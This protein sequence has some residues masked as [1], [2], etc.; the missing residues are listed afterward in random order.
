MVE[1]SAYGEGIQITKEVPN[2]FREILS[3]DAVAFVAKLAREFTPRVEERLQARQDRQERINAGEMPDFLP[4]TKDVRE[5]DWKIAPIP[6]ALQDRRVEITGPPDRKMLINALNCRAPTYMTDFEDANCPT[7]HNMLDSQRNLK[8]AIERTISFDDPKTGKHYTLNDEVAVLIARPR[9]WHLFEKHMLVDGKQVP[10]GI[11]DFGLYFFHNAQ[12][13]LDLGHGPYFYLP[14]MESHLEARLWN[15]IFS[16]IKKFREHDMLLPDRNT[17]TMTV[18]FMRAYS[19]LTIKTCHQRGAHAMGGMA[20]QIPRSDDPEWTEFAN[21]KVREDKER[22][23]KD[24]HDGTWVAHPGM[25]GLAMEAFNEYMPQPNQIDKIPDVNPSAADL[26]EKPEGQITMDGF[27]NN[28]SVGVQ[29]LGAWLAGRGAVPVFNLMEDA[30][31]AEI[32]RAQVW[33]WIHHP[34][35]IL[36]DGT[37]VTVDLFRQVLDE[38]LDKIKNDIVGPE[39]WEQDEFGTAA[40][41]FDRISTQDEFVEFLTLPGYEYLD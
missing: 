22:E 30:A 18:P 9:G 35:G 39:R 34:Q 7:W 38:E 5:G 20:A 21:N 8:E 1:K 25:V 40:Q 24:G 32:S 16:Y 29:Y 4:E 19:L 15:Y 12:R 31:T 10:G 13:L 6:D 14:K 23:A 33:Q 3:P 41:L 2:E 11:F 17:V 37:E 26:L 27:R 36:E 28:I